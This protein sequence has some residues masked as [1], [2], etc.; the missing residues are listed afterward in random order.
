MQEQSTEIL[1]IGAG[2]GGY[3]AAIRAAQN[4]RK[5]TLVDKGELGGTCLNVG[6]IPSK[7]LIEAGHYAAMPARAASA[8]IHYPEP[9]IDFQKLQQ[10]KT[11]IV[12]QLTGGVKGLLQAAGVEIVKGEASFADANR[13]KVTGGQEITFSHCIIATGSSP[14]EIPAFPF[15]ERTLSSTEALALTKKPESV[16]VIGGGYIGIELGTMFANFGTKVTIIEGL[17]GILP[18]FPKAMSALAA[19]E[20]KTRSNVA[21]H[22]E[23]K[24]RKVDTAEQSAVITYEKGGETETLESEYVLVTV[25]RK[26]NTEKLEL[27]KAG[28]QVNEKGFIEVS[29]S[30]R[31]SVHHIFAIG[32]IT[33]GPALAHRASM[34]GKL[35]SEAME[36]E[37]GDSSDYVIP[38]VVFSEPPLAVVGLSKEAAQQEGYEVKADSF[39]MSHNGRAL[40][41]NTTAGMVTL[42][43]DKADG[44]ILGAEASGEGAPELINE[45]ALCIQSGLTAEDVSLVVHAHPTLGESVMEAAE[46]VIGT[47]IHQL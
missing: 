35:V 7:A 26:P 29:P 30:C 39:P 18:G 23:T 11:G 1:I 33:P 8:G 36:G 34:Q 19:E 9:E 40:T 15:N 32:D 3:V 4:G 5:V 21:V 41:L 17:P 6:C 24:V 43:T 28:I 22:T 10:W 46:K 16:T 37:E 42:I 12:K 44:T 14:V 31:T 27:E 25:G 45:L 38:A 20:L 2:P 13:I 47:P